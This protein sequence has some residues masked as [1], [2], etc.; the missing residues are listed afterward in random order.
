MTGYV[1][2]TTIWNDF[3]IAERFGTAEI[4]N[5]YDRIMEEWKG[6]Y[7]YLT[8]LV[9]ILNWNIWYWDGAGPKYAEDYARLYNDLWLAA[10]QYAVDHLK[11]EELEYFIRTVD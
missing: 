9:M 3:M 5:T 11:G 8:E 10:D 7:I 4:Q 6:N 2:Q 1:P